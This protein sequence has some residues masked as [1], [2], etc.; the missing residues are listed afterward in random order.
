MMMVEAVYTS[1]TLIYSNE[2]TRPYNPEGSNLNIMFFVCFRIV[3]HVYP[4]NNRGALDDIG[5]VEGD[6]RINKTS[7]ETLESSGQK[8]PSPFSSKKVIHESDTPHGKSSQAA[9][10]VENSCLHVS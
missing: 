7:I 1:E 2:T 10:G 8:E 9:E 3:I 5:E 6:D 4:E